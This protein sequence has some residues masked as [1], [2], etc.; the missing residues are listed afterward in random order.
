[1][2]MLEQLKYFVVDVDG[3]LTDSGIYYDDKGNETKKFS[4]RD[5]AGF[6]AF[7]RLGINVIILTGRNSFSTKKRMKDLKVKYVF[8]GVK[9][10]YDFLY[11]FMKK[12]HIKKEE[13]GYIGDDLNDLMPMSLVGYTACP[14]DSCEEIRKIANYVSKFNGG[15]GAFRDTVEHILK[16]TDKWDLV[17]NKYCSIGI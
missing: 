1:M 10:K 9:N 16:S 14:L 11:N 17:I 12:N 7:M 6:F 15:Y 13:I 8:Q 5:A 2:V 3:T 4:T